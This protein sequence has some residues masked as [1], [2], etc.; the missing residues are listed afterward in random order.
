MGTIITGCANLDENQQQEKNNLTLTTTLSFSDNAGTKALTAAGVKTFAKDD[1]VV[2]FYKDGKGQTLR[3]LSNALTASD[4]S[5]DGKTATITVSI[6]NLPETNGAVRYVYP[7]NMAKASIATSAEINDD[8][9][10]DFTQLTNQKGTLDDLG[11]SLDLCVF[12]GNFTG[13]SLPASASLTNRLAILAI[14][15]TDNAA[16]PNDITSTITNVTVN[17][18]TNNYVVTRS[19]AAGPIYVAIKPTSSAAIEV[20]ASA[21][22]NDYGKFL[23]SKTYAA[24][25][26]YNVSWKMLPKIDLSTAGWSLHVTEDMIITGTPSKSD[27]SIDCTV[28]CEVILYNVNSGG[29]KVVILDGGYHHL[30]IKLK[31][32]SILKYISCN[33]EYNLT[34]DEAE[35]G[36]TVILEND[37]STTLDGSTVTINGGTVKAKSTGYRAVGCNLVVNGG[38]VYIAGGYYGGDQQAVWG[39][40]TA[41]AG[42]TLYEWN[43]GWGAIS[44]SPSDKRYITTDNTSGDPTSPTNPAWTW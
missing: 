43:S 8:N 44:S 36:G 12:D 21:G 5:A 4:I 13:T 3:V 34:I 24:N 25:N 30:S 20:L 26:G 33:S 22:A 35:T 6:L 17:E 7:A 2:L 27:I 19:A 10:I 39:T 37:D 1:Q 31:G 11:S 28:D 29:T 23:T 40:I 41:G 9:T 18:G 32:T 15:L 16:T 42:V 14:T 38:N